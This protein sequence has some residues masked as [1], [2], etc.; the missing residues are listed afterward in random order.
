MQLVR[1]LSFGHR[2]T[3]GSLSEWQAAHEQALRE[4]VFLN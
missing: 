1:E 3:P 4:G 2:V